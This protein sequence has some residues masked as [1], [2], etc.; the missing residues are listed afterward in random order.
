MRTYNGALLISSFSWVAQNTV[1]SKYTCLSG[2]GGLSQSQNLHVV[3]PPAVLSSLI[4]MALIG[5]DR[6]IGGKCHFCQSITGLS[7]GNCVT[8]EE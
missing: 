4:A 5:E 7:N 1:F 3:F 6:S 8:G 2:C